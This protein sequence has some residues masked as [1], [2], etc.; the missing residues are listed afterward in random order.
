[1]VYA[2]AMMT[3]KRF[4]EALGR[5]ALWSVGR[6]K[7]EGT[8]KRKYEY[9]QRLRIYPHALREPNAYYSPQKKALLF[10]YFT[11]PKSTA[12]LLPGGTIFTCL[13]HDVIA[14][15][16]TH[17]LLDGMH[18]RFAEPSNP[19]VLAFHEAFADLVALFQHFSYPEVL[20]HQLARARGDL[21]SHT[22]LGELAHEFG[23][24]IG[25][26]GS[27]RSALGRHDPKSGKWTS[28]T[29]DPSALSR[30]NQPHERG[31]ILVAAVFGAFLQIYQTRTR[32]LFRIASM[33]TG[34]LPPG[35]LHPDLVNRLASE[36]SKTAHHF[37]RM[38]IR[39][40]DYCPPVDITFG[41]YLRALI[42]SDKDL[43]ADDKRNYRVAVIDSF[44]NWGIH[45]K[46]IY[47]LS[48]ESLIWQKPNE[49]ELTA[50]QSALGSAEVLRNLCPDW[51]LSSDR[52]A[53][54][55]QAEHNQEKLQNSLLQPPQY[56]AVQAMGLTID[57]NYP[58]SL[59]ASKTFSGFPALEIHAVR[60]ARRVGSD[61]E[62]KTDL[63]ILATQKRKG[64]FDISTQGTVDSGNTAQDPDFIFRGGCTILVDLETGKVRYIIKKSVLS[65]ER[66]NA[67]R[68][69]LL[70]KFLPSAQ[71]MY[72]SS[73]NNQGE[74]GFAEPFAMLHRHKH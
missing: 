59:S 32:D 22:L 54:Y 63:V 7:E 40:L 46:G 18:R 31:A 9:V 45:P 56:Q 41:E 51:G 33:G 55:D 24:A 65:E 10:G 67:Q 17:A 5:R 38:C 1:M 23:Q 47:S 6:Y 37:L 15:E 12:G 4:E 29:P 53:V 27:L 13:S 25:S 64:Y 43:F 66:L 11:V 2:V 28:I 57:E 20:R 58:R 16:T 69:Y 68:Q 52:K 8:G 71:K 44:R 70:E 62:V 21:A 61:G 26:H 74:E 35:E 72:F 60:P 50:L 19:D 14:H 36:A 73:S 48:E 49:S 3:I 42:T 34:I 30:I 39:A